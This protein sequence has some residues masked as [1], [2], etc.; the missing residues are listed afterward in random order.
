MHYTE[1][2]IPRILLTVLTLFLAGVLQCTVKHAALSLPSELVM[3][4]KCNSPKTTC[5]SSR[6]V[7]MRIEIRAVYRDFTR[8]TNTIVVHVFK[9]GHRDC[10]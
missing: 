3:T 7:E 10:I 9:R 4:I 2:K 5:T 6:V 1:I 8:V